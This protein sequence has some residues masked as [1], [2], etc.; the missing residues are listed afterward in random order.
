M[1][2]VFKPALFFLVCMFYGQMTIAGSI[3]CRG[4][5]IEDGTLE[6]VLKSSVRR[7]CGKPESEGFDSDIYKMPNG[8]RIM[9][10]YNASNN[11]EVIEE[12]SEE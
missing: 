10:R 1:N 2:S 9:V 7:H 5:I 12:V 11:V 8:T 6:P 4:H 3:E